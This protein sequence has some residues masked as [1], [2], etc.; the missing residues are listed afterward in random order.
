MKAAVKVGDVIKSLDFP[1]N[2]ECYRIGK[3]VAIDG[4]IYTC[5]GIEIMWEGRSKPS[6]QVE[7]L[8]ST[9]MEG[10]HMF[11][12]YFPGRITVITQ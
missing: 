9:P 5:A 2:N 7:E 12:S 6:T 8:F 3:V 11:D 10:A 4:E 1:G